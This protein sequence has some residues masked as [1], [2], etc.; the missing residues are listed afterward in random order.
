MASSDFLVEPWPARSV[1]VAPPLPIVTK[2]DVTQA[3]VELTDRVIAARV[4]TQMDREGK[5]PPLIEINGLGAAV[6]AAK[7]SI[8]DVRNETAGLSIDA[9]VLV[10]ALQDVRAQ[11]K[12]AHADLKF[13][14]ET[15][16]NGGATASGTTSG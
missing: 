11:I 14:A 4:V 6:V 5:L 13:E 2:P 9:S 10:S 3:L 15:L 7:K 8:A 12:Q 16:G 1:A